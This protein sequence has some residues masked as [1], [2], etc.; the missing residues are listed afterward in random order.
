MRGLQSGR[1]QPGEHRRLRPAPR[2]LLDA[3]ALDLVRELLVGAPARL[4]LAGSAIPGLAP[5]RTRRSTRSPAASATCSAIRPP[6]EYPTSVKRS[7]PAAATTSS[8]TASSVT[9]TRSDA[10]PC[11]RMSGAT[12]V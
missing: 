3:R 6:I 9:G 8:I 4:A 2:E 10:S 7:G 5:I 12:D 11:P 1:G